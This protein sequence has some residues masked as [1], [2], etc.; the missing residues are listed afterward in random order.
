M[1]VI[2]VINNASPYIC[3]KTSFFLLLKALIPPALILLRIALARNY[4]FFWVNPCCCHHKDSSN[5]VAVAQAEQYSARTQ[6]SSAQL[7]ILIFSNAKKTY[8]VLRSVPYH[9]IAA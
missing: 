4:I 3:I 1:F 9:M 7:N 2:Q 5:N 6:C 8:G